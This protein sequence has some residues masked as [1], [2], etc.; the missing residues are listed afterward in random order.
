MPWAMVRQGNY[1]YCPHSD[2]QAAMLFDLEQDPTES[3][4]LAG[5]QRYADVQRTLAGVLAQ[6]IAKPPVV[7]TSALSR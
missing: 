4:N 1:K 3:V 5:D 2:E 7:E 6:R